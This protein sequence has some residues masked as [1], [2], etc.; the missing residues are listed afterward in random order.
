M[1]RREVIS[2]PT[3]PGATDLPYSSAV[4]V[5][6]NSVFTSGYV[7]FEPATG[8]VPAGIEAQTAQT[9]DN[10]K[11]VLEAAGSTLGHVVK[12][13]VYLVRAEDYQAMN[14]IYKRYF[15]AE[16]PARTTVVVQLVRPELLVEIELVA[17]LAQ[18]AE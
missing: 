1:I 8:A 12:A 18:G 6:G 14:A 2:L 11:A 5:N 3:V 4:I 17:L 9:L 13:T 15:P 10:L 7:G 16:R